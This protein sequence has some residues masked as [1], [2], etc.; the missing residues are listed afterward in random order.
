MSDF[1]ADGRAVLMTGKLADPETA[2]ARTAEL[3]ARIADALSLVDDASDAELRLLRESGVF[4]ALVKEWRK[5]NARLLAA[6]ADEAAG[7]AAFKLRPALA[8]E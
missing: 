6:L 1:Y 8:A 5:E 7:D 3:A 4:A 2:T